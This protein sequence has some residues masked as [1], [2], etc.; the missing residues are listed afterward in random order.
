MVEVQDLLAVALH[1]GAGVDLPV[2]QVHGLLDV[3]LLDLLVPLDLGM[4]QGGELGE[5][6]DEVDALAGVRLL[7]V[8]LDV[9]EEAQLMEGGHAGLHPLAQD[10]RQVGLA[11]PDLEGV[12]D[13]GAVHGA[14]ALED[15]LLD[16]HLLH[17]A[18][19]EGGSLGAVDLLGPDGRRGHH[20]QKQEKRQQQTFRKGQG[21][22][23]FWKRKTI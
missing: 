16:L 14:V 22:V 2:Q 7:H 20:P 5:G 12:H 8:D 15:D 10:G 9:L 6:E 18:A 3:V 13:Q 19:H 21:T 11:L 17:G 1:R 4:G 23:L